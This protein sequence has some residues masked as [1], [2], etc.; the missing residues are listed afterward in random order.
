MG[1]LKNLL[2]YFL[3]YLGQVV[4]R[5]DRRLILAIAF[6]FVVVTYVLLH[7]RGLR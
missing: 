6:F 1:L 5:I 3:I 2:T 7:L 4:A